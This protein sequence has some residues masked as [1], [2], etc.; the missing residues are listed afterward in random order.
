MVSGES[1]VS[2][3]LFNKLNDY[4]EEME[5][6]AKA[7]QEAVTALQGAVNLFQGAASNWS[8]ITPGFQN[9]LQHEDMGQASIHDAR[10]AGNIGEA[11]HAMD[12]VETADDMEAVDSVE[13]VNS[14]DSV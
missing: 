8:S 3:E 4:T 12:A 9:A 6:S 5:K 14:G 2:D 13:A 11:V 1:V 10:R 7:M